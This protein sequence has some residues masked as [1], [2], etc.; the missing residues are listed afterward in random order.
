MDV[1]DEKGG[2]HVTLI[3]KTREGDLNEESMER[4]LSNLTQ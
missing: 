3:D 4:M 1:L 2:S